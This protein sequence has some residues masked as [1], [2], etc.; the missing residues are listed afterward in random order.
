MTTKEEK[1]TQIQSLI[2]S[3]YTVKKA[4]KKA[5]V[6]YQTYYNWKKQFG[7]SK[8]KSPKTGK[9]TELKMQTLINKFFREVKKL[10]D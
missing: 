2:N 4:C 9:N 8:K 1:Y 3:G 5:K 10:L 6:P 7:G